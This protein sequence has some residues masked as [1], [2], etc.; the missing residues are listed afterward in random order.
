MRSVT[1]MSNETR[2]HKGECEQNDWHTTMKTLSSHAVGN[3]SRTLPIIRAVNFVQLEKH[4]FWFIA[5]PY[6]SVLSH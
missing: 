4:R 3:N 2:G 6:V 5:Q 1:R